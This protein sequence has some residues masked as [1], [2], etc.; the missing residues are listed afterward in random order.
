[1]AVTPT[2][3]VY[4]RAFEFESNIAVLVLNTF[5]GNNAIFI[6]PFYPSIAKMNGVKLANNDLVNVL[7]DNTPV[8]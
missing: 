5:N 3:A 7:P 2:G 4:T 8:A 6:F 1:M